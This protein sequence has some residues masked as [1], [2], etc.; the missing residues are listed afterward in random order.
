MNPNEP[1]ANAPKPDENQ[2]NG[3]SPNSSVQ[4]EDTAPVEMPTETFGQENNSTTEP[5][6]VSD[7][8]TPST[9]SS[10]FPGEETPTTPPIAPTPIGGPAIQPKK[11]NKK[12]VL[13]FIATAF[14]VAGLATAGYFVGQS[15]QQAAAPASEETTTESNEDATPVAPVESASDVENEINAIQEDIDAVS[16]EDLSGDPISDD[17][18]NAAE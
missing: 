14:L 17:S 18:L 3:F 5:I 2:S 4:P 16:D 7:S 8:T 10:S 11:S 13:V 12:K 9:P 6:P 1:E 15:L